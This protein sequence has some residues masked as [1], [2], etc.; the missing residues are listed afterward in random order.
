MKNMRT[1]IDKLYCVLRFESFPARV[2]AAYD[3]LLRDRPYVV[4]RQEGESHKSAVWSASAQARERGVVAGMP[5]HLMRKKF[6]AVD[7]VDYNEA[8]HAAALDEL[9]NLLL[10]YTPDVT[11]SRQGVCLLDLSRTP[12]G[13]IGLPEPVI[14]TLQ[15][16]VS[17]RTGLGRPAAGL[18]ASGVVAGILA[19]LAL[20]DGIRICQ[21][22]GETEL[23]AGV[24]TRMLPGLSHGC[25]E[26]LRKYGLNTVGQVRRLDRIDLVK[27]FGGEGERLYR[28]VHGFDIKDSVAPPPP[29]FVETVL[30]RDT[31]DGDLL[32]QYL[33]RTVDRFCN[34]TRSARLAVKSAV[35]SI[36][37]T[38][39]KRAQKTVVFARETGDYQAIARCVE[40]A[41]GELY[42]RRVGIRSL[43][44]SGRRLEED[45]GQTDL[46][47]SEW[48][49]KQERLG[50]SIARVRERGGFDAVFTGRDF[51]AYVKEVNHEKKQ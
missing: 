29:F 12:I 20:P 30:E 13:R 1:N 41:F 40:R 18:S 28:L 32:L 48:D 23:L 43:M 17:G 37:Y 19:R 47:A 45:G 33:H 6:G 10:R 15:A 31:A 36:G 34:L 46:F 50:A 38:D 16:E 8:H 25:R 9:E 2:A 14:A 4:V 44:L 5:V 11:V 7:I 42:C 27:R 24:E 51:G 49:D 3:P 39:R 35:L 26:R 21:S 22:G